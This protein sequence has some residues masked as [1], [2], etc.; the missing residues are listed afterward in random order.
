MKFDANLNISVDCFVIVHH[1]FRQYTISPDKATTRVDL[2][3]QVSNSRH[4]TIKKGEH[5]ICYNTNV[6]RETTNTK[7][8]VTFTLHVNSNVR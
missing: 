2:Q 4:V 6:N 3:V 5:A 7:R 1:I 8:D